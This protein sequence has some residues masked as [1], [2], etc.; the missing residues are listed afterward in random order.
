MQTITL[1][2]PAITCGHCVMTIKRV[3]EEEVEG[4]TE[5]TGDHEA[6]QVTI[7]F[8]APATIEQITET[9]TEWDYPPATN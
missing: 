4:V 9:M 6:K 1:D 8:A 3:V 7:S 2:V 5:V